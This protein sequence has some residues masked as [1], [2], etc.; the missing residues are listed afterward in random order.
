MNGPRTSV[1]GNRSLGEYGHAMGKFELTGELPA[2]FFP[3]YARLSGQEFGTE[4]LP[5]LDSYP[6]RLCG[7]CPQMRGAGSHPY[8]NSVLDRP[9]FKLNG[10]TYAQP[11][12]VQF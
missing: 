10:F 11:A 3:E 4:N 1:Q 7:L 6:Q 9:F 2:K 5:G 12:S 8:T